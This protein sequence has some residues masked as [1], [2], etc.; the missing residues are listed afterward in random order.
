MIIGSLIVIG[1]GVLTIAFG[2]ILHF[3]E[4]TERSKMLLVI[5]G[6]I[7]FIGIVL[8]IIGKVGVV[9]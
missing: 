7:L 2:F 5:G 3:I 4:M 8:L 9:V 6:I 1:I